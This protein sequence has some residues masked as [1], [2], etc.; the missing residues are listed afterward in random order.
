M[1][2]IGQVFHELIS[3]WHSVDCHT[4]GQTLRATGFLLTVSFNTTFNGF[5]SH[6]PTKTVLNTEALLILLLHN[7][8]Q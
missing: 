7:R 3:S 2:S 5:L 4:I 6:D 8:Q 1:F